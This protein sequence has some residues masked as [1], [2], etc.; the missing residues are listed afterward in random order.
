MEWIIPNNS[1]SGLVLFGAGL[2]IIWVSLKIELD[3]KS[4]LSGQTTKQVPYISS[5]EQVCSLHTKELYDFVATQETTSI[6]GNP[7]KWI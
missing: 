3:F 2:M 4:Q 6:R 7:M 5:S 1:F